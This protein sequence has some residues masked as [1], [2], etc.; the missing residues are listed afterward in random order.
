MRFV[1]LPIR[2]PKNNGKK[3]KKGRP[4][5]KPVKNPKK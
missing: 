5:I 3:G 4:V 1:I 2:K